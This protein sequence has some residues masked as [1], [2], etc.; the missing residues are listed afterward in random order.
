[1]LMQ[2]GVVLGHF[3]LAIG[4]Q[5][6][7]AKIRVIQTLPIPIKQKDVRYFLGHVGYYRHLIKEAESNWRL[8][9]NE[10]FLQLKQL[11]NTAPVLQGPDWNFPFH[12]YTDASDYA[13]CVILGKQSQNIEMQ[14][15]ILARTFMDWN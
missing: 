9:C 1:M 6:D 3:I 8:E 7:L 4:I 14:Y 13:I 12:I 10:A 15:T 2:E 11:L 5:V